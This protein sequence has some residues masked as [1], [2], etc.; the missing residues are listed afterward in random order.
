[1]NYEK[2]RDLQEAL[3][4]DSF[5]VR[6]Q[7]IENPCITL[8]CLS[9]DRSFVCA[10]RCA[11][12]MREHVT[13]SEYCFDVLFVGSLLLHTYMYIQCLFRRTNPI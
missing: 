6:V 12:C 11:C 7:W 5:Q 13:T 4:Y 3:G 2:E 8:V 9:F 10:R 1:M